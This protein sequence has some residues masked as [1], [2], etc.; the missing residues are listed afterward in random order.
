MYVHYTSF[1]PVKMLSTAT[2]AAEI[3]G[4]CPAL[5]L[6]GGRGRNPKRAANPNHI[7]P[8]RLISLSDTK[9]GHL[10]YFADWQSKNGLSCVLN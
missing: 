2:S 3:G 7:E 1:S 9:Q 4:R 6:T 10:A 8:V 5:F